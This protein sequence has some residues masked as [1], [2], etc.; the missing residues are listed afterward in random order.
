MADF[1][2]YADPTAMAHAAADHITAL[3]AE[4]VAARGQC[5]IALSGGSTPR[6]TYAVL[7]TGEF[8]SR[9]DWSRLHVFWGDERSVPPDHPDSDY[10]MAREA[11]L[12]H[13]PIPKDNVH[14]IH[15]ERDPSQAADDY[16][17]ELREFFA[18]ETVGRFDL[19]LLGMGEDG[20]TASLFPGAGAL[21]ERERWV[22]AYYVEALDTWRITLTPT[23][24]NTAANV[25]FLVAGQNKA[26][27]LHRVIAGPH[28]PDV[29]P[30][31]IVNPTRGRLT[32]FLDRSAASLLGDA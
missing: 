28:Q 2:V 31:Q 25:T 18:G 23:I 17:R 22:V 29:L 14:R 6:A 5:T 7:A 27:M 10:R 12:Q 16:E 13:V 20:H 15:A 24:I 8:A 32:W 21:A 4:A 3:A 1:Q 19:I 11:L 9:V 30:A 26:E